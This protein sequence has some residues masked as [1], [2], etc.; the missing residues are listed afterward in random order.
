MEVTP[1]AGTCICYAGE[2]LNERIERLN[3]IP[4]DIVMSD[5]PGCGIGALELVY[6]RLDK[7]YKD[8]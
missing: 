7:D 8:Q 4:K 6:G 3:K 2:A 1:L 5:I